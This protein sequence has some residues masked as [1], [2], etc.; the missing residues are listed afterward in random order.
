MGC[1]SAAGEL[2]EEGW[3]GAEK[4]IIDHENSKT[5]LR[6]DDFPRLYGL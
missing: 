1:R 5:P 4:F 3:T 2:S 6:S